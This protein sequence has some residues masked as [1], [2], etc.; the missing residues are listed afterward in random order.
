MDEQTRKALE[1]I[2]QDENFDGIMKA[3]KEFE[4]QEDREREAFINGLSHAYRSAQDK[5]STLFTSLLSVG[6][7][8]KMLPLF[9]VYIEQERERLFGV[10]TIEQ[11]LERR[12]QMIENGTYD[13]EHRTERFLSNAL[14]KDKETYWKYR[15]TQDEWALGENFHSL[16]TALRREWSKSPLT[17]FLTV[18]IRLL[19][20]IV[21]YPMPTVE[22]MAH[23]KSSQIV[24]GLDTFTAYFIL[25]MIK[26][27]RRGN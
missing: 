4:E 2:K 16:H 15:R 13:Y 12:K 8:A 18:Y 6:Q 11:L 23:E 9:P 10:E 22:D 19:Y 5:H 20:T 7:A 25:T 21:D 3:L 26:E 17:Y 24:K 27:E 14:L 1:K